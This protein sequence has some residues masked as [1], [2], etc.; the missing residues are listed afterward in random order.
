M[1]EKKRFRIG[2][3]VVN[4]CSMSLPMAEAIVDIA[5][6]ALKDEM[7]EMDVATAI[8][9]K[10]VERYSA[11]M[12]QVIVGRSFGAFGTHEEGHYLYF[13]LGQTGFCVYAA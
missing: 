7:T 8:K 9:R 1:S 11:H 12:W 13:Y 3:A 10:L 2:E 5:G 4:V 6:K